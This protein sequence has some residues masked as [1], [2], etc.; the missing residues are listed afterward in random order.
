MP[1]TLRWARAAVLIQR[2]SLSRRLLPHR[3]LRHPPSTSCKTR[4]RTTATGWV[5]LLLFKCRTQLFL[6]TSP[7]KKKFPLHLWNYIVHNL[8][9]FYS[10]NVNCERHKM[11][12]FESFRILFLFHIGILQT[13]DL[14]KQVLIKFVFS[15]L[16]S[17]GFFFSELRAII[18]LIKANILF[19][20]RHCINYEKKNLLYCTSLFYLNH[21]W[22]LPTIYR[23]LLREAKHIVRRATQRWNFWWEAMPWGSPRR[24]RESRRATSSLR[25]LT[26]KSKTPCRQICQ[27]IRR[28]TITSRRTMETSQPRN[29]QSKWETQRLLPLVEFQAMA[30]YSMYKVGFLFYIQLLNLIFFFFCEIDFWQFFEQNVIQNFLGLLLKTIFEIFFCYYSRSI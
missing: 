12:T 26:R 21:C 22:F 7:K 20:S 4:A 16:F 1:R 27:I 5:L 24:P 17:Q 19:F 14:R 23:T 25:M 10:C 11:Y 30:S 28:W 15:F 13:T 8:A 29:H 2:P 9:G 6:T 3:S 18:N